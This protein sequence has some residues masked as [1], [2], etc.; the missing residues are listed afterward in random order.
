MKRILFII[1]FIFI[2]IPLYAGELKPYQFPRVYDG[3]DGHKWTIKE[4]PFPDIFRHKVYRYE[5]DDG[6]TFTIRQKAFPDRFGHEEY[7]VKEED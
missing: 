3:K 5:R 7:E 4:D 6:K 2:A 1:F